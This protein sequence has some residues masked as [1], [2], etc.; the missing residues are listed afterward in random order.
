MINR[1]LHKHTKRKQKHTS[2][3]QE[4]YFHQRSHLLPF[5][6]SILGDF[7][8]YDSI[9]GPCQNPIMLKCILHLVHVMSHQWT[10]NNIELRIKRCEFCFF[11]CSD[12]T[13]PSLRW[14]FYYLRLQFP[15]VLTNLN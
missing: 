8:E 11:F 1:K 10:G 7:K 4:P 9:I 3:I 14:V 5:P 6:S 13:F 15:S 2:Q 12:Q